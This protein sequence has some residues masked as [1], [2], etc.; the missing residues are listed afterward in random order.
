MA[1]YTYT[2][3]GN[4]LPLVKSSGTV[5]LGYRITSGDGTGYIY[6]VPPLRA[7]EGIGGPS[8]RITNPAWAKRNQRTASVGMGA[9]GQQKRHL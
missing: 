2:K 4:K 6:I 9:A 1:L 7:D 5:N 8:V 3:K